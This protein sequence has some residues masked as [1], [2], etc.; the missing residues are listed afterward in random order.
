MFRCAICGVSTEH[1]KGF[2][3]KVRHAPHYLLLCFRTPFFCVID[4]KRI[5]GKAGDCL[6]HRPGETVI[7]GPL[8]DASQFIND[9]IY[10]SADEGEME[11]LA[12]LFDTLIPLEKADALA[13]SL[14]SV[15]KESVR[16][17][18]FSARLVSDTI[19]RMLVILK[20]AEGQQKKEDVSLYL[21]FSGARVKILNHYNE[22][23]DLAKMAGL[24]GYSVSRFCALYTEFFGQSPMN[25]L[26][27]KRLEMAK[28]LLALRAYKV[29]DVADMCG[30]ASIHYFSNF[31][32]KRT[33]KS[34]AEYA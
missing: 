10:F 8:D 1:K 23:W 12:P 2:V 15:M 22:K 9:W 17:D 18:P 25:D 7:H 34:P 13:A 6:L 11:Q 3:F 27:D 4:G 31:F 26:L 33:G 30:F 14:N 19:Y 5:E 21:R 32:K 29:G 24:L 28:Q 20:R 16:N